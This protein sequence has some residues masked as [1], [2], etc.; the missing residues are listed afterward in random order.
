MVAREG[1]ALSESN[2]RAGGRRD[3]LWVERYGEL[4]RHR[5]VFGSMPREVVAPVGAELE[6]SRLAGWV[7]YQRRRETRGVMSAW[8]RDLLAQVPGFSWDPLE[9][10]WR[11]VCV[12]LAEFLEV[13]HRMP[14]Y[15]STSDLEHS[16]AAWVH[17]QRFLHRRGVLPTRR[18]VALERLQF[19]IL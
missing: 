2:V 9:D 6:E 1:A 12:Q 18:V 17:K 5:V 8:Q 15:R 19:R 11:L 14:R 16:L 3:V 13:E 10:Q 7:R 4:V